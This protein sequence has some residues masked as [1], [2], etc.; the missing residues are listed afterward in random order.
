MINFLITRCTTK[1]MAGVAMING[2]ANGMSKL[3]DDPKFGVLVFEQDYKEQKVGEWPLL[4]QFIAN[5]PE[6]DDAFAWADCCIDLGGLCRGYDPYREQ[7]ISRCR[8]KGIQYI[9][10]PVSFVNP[11]P[12]I[13]KG[14]PAVARGA[15]S[16]NAYIKATG[17]FPLIAPDISFLVEPAKVNWKDVSEHWDGYGNFVAVTTH[18]GKPWEWF[19]DGAKLLGKRGVFQV[20]FKDSKGGLNEPI[21][22]NYGGSGPP[23]ALYGIIRD[24]KQVWTCRYHAAV[25]AIMA[26]IEYVFPPGM[27]NH[28]K[29]EDLASWGGRD[30]QSI[31]DEAMEAC[32]YIKETIDGSS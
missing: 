30:L 21:L 18:K 16:S 2:F 27:P 19:K 11:D 12:K 31:R 17:E 24:S 15:N 4:K 26:G 1:D 22:T 7:Y 3:C 25:A 29:Y 9:Y 8:A 23:E 28:G 6:I 20:V 14:I 10:G 13:V 5:R 32:K